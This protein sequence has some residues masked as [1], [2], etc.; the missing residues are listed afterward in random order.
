MIYTIQVNGIL[1]FKT[2]SMKEAYS[3]YRRLDN[4][5]KNIA[6]YLNG[7]FMASDKRD[8]WK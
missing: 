6:M 7:K 5:K 3:E 2:D 4:E 8:R 1:A